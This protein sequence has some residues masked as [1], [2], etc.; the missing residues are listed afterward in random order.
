MHRAM[1]QSHLTRQR[2]NRPTALGLRLLASHGLYLLPN[3]IIVF[4]RPARPRRVAQAL[5][6]LLGKGAAPLPYR[7]LRDAE[8]QRD[9]LIGLAG[10]SRQ[11]DT[12]AQRNRLRS[13]RSLSPT[14]QRRLRL[15]VEDN[16]W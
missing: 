2:T 5:Q 14:V 1:R 8:V 11:H 15:C 13:R 16:R 4:G 6:T 9:L 7:D 3:R 10:S 12:A